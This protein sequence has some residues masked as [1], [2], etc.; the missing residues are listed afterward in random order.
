MPFSVK[1]KH[2]K[3]GLVLEIDARFCAK[4][5]QLKPKLLYIVIIF[6]KTVVKKL[7][8]GRITYSMVRIHFSYHPCNLQKNKNSYHQNGP[9]R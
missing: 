8:V 5:K 2:H 3:F 7:T 1:N 9:V 4:A 6:F